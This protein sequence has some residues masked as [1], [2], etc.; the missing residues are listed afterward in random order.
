MSCLQSIS[1]AAVIVTVLST[2]GQA[3]AKEPGAL[4]EGWEYG[5]VLDLAHTSRALELGQRESGTSIGHSDLVVSGPLG[6]HFNAQIGAATHRH[7]GQW[8]V[9][10]ESAWVQ[11]RS[12]PY[13]FQSRLG[14][15]ASQIGYLNEQHPHADD[16]VERPLLYRSFLGGHWFDDGVRLNWTAPTAY[17]VHLGTEIFHSKQLVK[18]SSAAKSP[19]ALTFTTKIGDDFNPEHSWQLGFSHLRLRRE[20]ASSD[21]HEDS[22]HDHHDH[23][24]GGHTHG[25]QFVGKKTNMVD[26]TWKWSPRGNNREQQ[27]RVNA[28]WAKVKELNRHARATDQHEAHSLAV[29]W[30][31]A[32]PWEVGVRTD[33]LKVSMPHGDHFH[34]GRLQED[35]AM[36]SWK[37]NH[38]QTL[39]GQWTV[40]KNAQ[41][42]THTAKRSIQIQYVLSFGAHGAH[43]F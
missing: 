29:V 26:F 15:F 23:A 2:Q 28:E 41:G 14:R 38:R 13:G 24:G 4:L 39:R 6:Q 35:S 40:Q 22:S 9:E 33:R 30:R 8:E 34:Q 42:F 25:A 32:Q 3:Y 17:Y 43:T 21:E 1:V 31:F 37:P 19:G 5:A 12:L 27:I 18:R 7:D 36:I 16:F 10:L 20:L 11:T